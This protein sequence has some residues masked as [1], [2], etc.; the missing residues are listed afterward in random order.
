MSTASGTQVVLLRGINV[1]GH[2]KV[3]MKELRAC[4]AEAGCQ[5]VETYIQSGNVV[6]HPPAV[7]D[8][9][10]HL[11]AAIEDRFGFP[12][13]VI[14][15]DAAAF[16][17]IAGADHPLWQEG[18]QDKYLYVGFLADR[19]T[20]QAVAGLDPDRSPG[21]RFLVR[22]REI[23]LH[24]PTGSARSKLTNAWFDRELGVLSTWRNWRTVGKVAALLRD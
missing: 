5:G 20:D 15:R 10:A 23:F 8:L 17:A 7:P 12:V 9:Q 4:L 2:N 11:A 22:G 6:L 3:P 24:F 13:P 1:G 21:D 16:L 19:P 18:A 14:T